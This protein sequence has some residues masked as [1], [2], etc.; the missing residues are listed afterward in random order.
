[1]LLY[2]IPLFHM[3][4]KLGMET[5]KERQTVYSTVECTARLVLTLVALEN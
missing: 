5:W 3:R 4:G 2:I 1:M